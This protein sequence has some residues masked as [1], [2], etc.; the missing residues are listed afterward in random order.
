VHAKS[1]RGE[2]KGPALA[3]NRGRRRGKVCQD[4]SEHVGNVL[5]DAR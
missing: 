3:G 4:L 2:I 5:R 1:P